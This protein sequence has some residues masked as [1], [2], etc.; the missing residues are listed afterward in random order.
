MPSLC[1]FYIFMGLDLTTPSVIQSSTCSFNKCIGEIQ[2][3]CCKNGSND[4]C[5]Q[6]KKT[7]YFP[8]SHQSERKQ[9]WMVALWYQGPR[10]FSIL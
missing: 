9:T 6:D 5:L 7:V 10:L 8:L 3:Q 4:K 1:I 2:A